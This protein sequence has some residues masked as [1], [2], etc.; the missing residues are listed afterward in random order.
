MNELA[1]QIHDNAVKHGF[2]DSKREIGTL[3]MLC[4]S[5]L[6]EALEADRHNEYA[7]VDI[8]NLYE[9]EFKNNFQKYIETIDEEEFREDFELY[10]K[11]R[12]EDE[13][14]DAIIRLLDICGYLNINIDKHIQLK[15]KYNQ[16]RENMHGKK[17]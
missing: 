8:E 6:S 11:D 1:K 10:I 4:V 14:A 15:M 12:F 16:M 5:E 7:R 3:L 13:I 9:D 2:Y 17:Y